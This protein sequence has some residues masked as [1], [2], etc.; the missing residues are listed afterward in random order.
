[1]KKHLYDTADMWRKVLYSNEAKIKH[2]GL[3]SKRHFWRKPNTT[4]HPVNTIPTCKQGGG[5]IML[6]DYFLSAG[7]GKLIRMEVTVD[8]ES[9]MRTCL[10]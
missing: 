1:V 10:N 4:H 2:F 7:F 9:L 8:G 3:N 6:W 5:S